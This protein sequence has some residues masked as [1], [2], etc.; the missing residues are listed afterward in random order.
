MIAARVPLIAAAVERLR[1]HQ[2]DER[3]RLV[4]VPDRRHSAAIAARAAVT[5]S[6]SR[7]RARCT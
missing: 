1:V 5:A 4:D 7:P 3:V 6:A 2:P